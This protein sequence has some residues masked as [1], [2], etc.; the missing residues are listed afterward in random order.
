VQFSLVQQN[1]SV[2]TQPAKLNADQVVRSHH[3][4]PAW[5]ERRCFQACG[6][7]IFKNSCIM[8]SFSLL[9]DCST[10]PSPLWMM[11]SLRLTVERLSSP[12][13]VKR[14][15]YSPEFYSRQQPQSLPKSSH[16]CM[17]RAQQSFCQTSTQLTCKD[18]CKYP[19]PGWPCYPTPRSEH[20]QLRLCGVG[21]QE[22]GCCVAGLSRHT[23]WYS[24]CAW[25]SSH[26][27]T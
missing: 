15:V 13:T 2:H 10:T 14:E 1:G 20:H 9:L 7:T 27:I 26:P 24:L 21:M 8:I 12:R 3:W 19:L 11:K 18:E 6:W 23:Q 22:A 16:I 4:K 25:D 5:H 17:S